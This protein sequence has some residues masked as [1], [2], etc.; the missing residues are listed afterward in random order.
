M[1]H[2]IAKKLN[3]GRK[4]S[5]ATAGTFGIVL[6]IVVGIITAR[7]S[8]AQTTTPLRFEVASIKPS[9]ANDQNFSISSQPGGRFTAN[10]PLKSLIGTA[11]GVRNHQI[12]GGPSWID[13]DKFTIEAKASRDPR[14]PLIYAGRK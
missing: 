6:P 5:L 12:S 14:H 9:E 13:S 1:R 8:Q 7:Q 11:Y 3:S 4:L 2:R 10:A